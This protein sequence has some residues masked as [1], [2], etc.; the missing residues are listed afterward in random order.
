MIIWIASY[1]KSGN[2]W[3]RSL[4]GAYLYSDDGIFNFNLLNK[5]DQF[6]GKQHFEFFLKDFKDLK[7]ISTHWIAAQ[8]RLNLYND[9][10]IFLKTHNAL[11]AI[12]NNPFTN[13]NNTKAAIYV[14]RD[15]R[16]VI[17]SLSHHYSMNIEEAFNFMTDSK[18]TLVDKKNYAS[19]IQVLGDWSNNFQS[20]KNIKF[21]PFLIVKYE[22]LI[23]DTKKT[24]LSILNF[25]KNFMDI[26]IDENKI[27]K[28]IESCSF[29]NLSKKEEIE[30]FKESVY[31]KKKDKKLNFFYLGKKNDWKNLL[32]PK[33]EEQIRFK[34]NKEMKEL[35]YN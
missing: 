19:V 29:E 6:P 16:N 3:V 15:P 18:I 31:S 34:F 30:G 20:W 5:I 32:D 28:T 11:C 10:I 17:T 14:V 35:E 21:A 24:F 25:L 23:K 8:D 13:K 7:K 33:I 27:L 4:L 9:G 2:T 1:P 22:D 12:E 26:K